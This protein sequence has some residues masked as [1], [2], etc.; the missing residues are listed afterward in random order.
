[1]RR[2]L[3]AV[4]TVVVPSS[5]LAQTPSP[6]PDPQPYGFV[7]APRD[8]VTGF[9]YLR[10]RWYDPKTGRFVLIDP[11]RGKPEDPGSQH[12]YVYAHG[13]PVNKTD[14]SGELTLTQISLGAGL[15]AGFASSGI[16]AYRGGSPQ[17]I[18]QAGIAT[19]LVTTATVYGAGA[20]P[21]VIAVGPA[22]LQLGR[23]QG[24][25][26]LVRFIE[27]ARQAGIRAS[28]GQPSTPPGMTVSQ[29]G[30]LIGWGTGNQAALL[31]IDAVSISALRLA[32]VTARM[33]AQWRDFYVNIALTNPGNPSA[34]GRAV[35][36]HEIA[37]QLL[38]E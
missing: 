19:G 2:V 16:T 14:P 18:V 29:F 22:L 5:T 1:M 30:Q 23:M 7:G 13:D 15:L 4:L 35:L 9:I 10:S 6:T 17:E 28:T 12:P 26:V 34:A 38:I 37:K 27:V 11:Q 8:P 36:M 20:A 3:A 31:R 33:A 24:T 32:G 25:S 21:V